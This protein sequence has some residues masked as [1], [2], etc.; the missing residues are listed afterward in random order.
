MDIVEMVLAGRVNKG[1]V[2]L[3]QR[4]GGSAVG[5]CG[6]D[7]NLL[8]AR[9]LV[10]QDIGYVGEV[11]QV[12]KQLLQSLVAATF[13][14]VV[15][16][17][18]VDRDTGHA[19]NV[20][21]DTAAGEIAASLQVCASLW[22]LWAHPRHAEAAPDKQHACAQPCAS[23]SRPDTAPVQAEKLIL[24]TDVPG[25][26]RDKDDLSTKFSELSVRETKELVQAGVITGGMIPKLSCCTRCIAQGVFAAHII[27]GRQKHS[28]L[29]EL[30]TGSG[31]GTMIRG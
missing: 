6:K 13:I 28:L 15:S 8:V 21:A 5:L 20:N 10:E 12:N 31:V 11:T 23:T 27:D 26:L 16:T 25:V 19:L 24:M 2:S 4:A 14:P 1:L 7:G 18:A 3:I 17:V 30:L 9:Q 22:P 29:L